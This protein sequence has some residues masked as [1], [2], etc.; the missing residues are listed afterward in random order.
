MI[1]GRRVKLLA[2]DPA[3]LVV[4]VRGGLWELAPLV[5]PDATC[6]G[7]WR[8]IPSYRVVLAVHSNSYPLVERGGLLEQI[9]YGRWAVELARGLPVLEP[10]GPLVAPQDLIGEHEEPTCARCGLPI[11][12]L[13]YR[14]HP[15]CAAV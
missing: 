11:A 4:L 10:P 5:P 1:R 14:F 15:H 9:D 3:E 2:L 12:G 13:V 6:H 7:G 8:D